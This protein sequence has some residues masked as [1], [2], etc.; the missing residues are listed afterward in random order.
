MITSCI[1]QQTSSNKTQQCLFWNILFWKFF[2]L[3]IH[4]CHVLIFL[5]NYS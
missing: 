4:P 3:H 2:I 1:V 5:W